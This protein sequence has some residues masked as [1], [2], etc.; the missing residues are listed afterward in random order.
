MSSVPT[1]ESVGYF[2]L[3]LRDKMHIYKKAG[4]YPIR[5]ELIF[6]LLGLIM[7]W[8]DGNTPSKKK[9]IPALL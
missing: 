5:F 1:D 8:L 6:C 4:M 3:S 7:R 9:I 2:H